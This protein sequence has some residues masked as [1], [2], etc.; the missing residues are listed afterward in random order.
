MIARMDEIKIQSKLQ[1]T[2][3]GLALGGNLFKEAKSQRRDLVLFYGKHENLEA[4]IPLTP[5]PANWQ[6][7]CLSLRPTYYYH[8]AVKPIFTPQK[9]L[10]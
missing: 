10:S 6:F 5:P 3:C 2:Q 1:R 9:S 8:I 4:G 7:V